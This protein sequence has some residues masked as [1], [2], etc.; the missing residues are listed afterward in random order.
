MKSFELTADSK[1]IL[2]LCGIFSENHT[3][4]E[5][6][7]LTLTEYNKVVSLLV[8]LKLSPRDILDQDILLDLKNELDAV[9][10]YRRIENLAK[11]GGALAL[12]I[13]SWFNKGLWVLTRNDKSYPPELKKR[14][15]NYAPPV[16]YGCGDRTLLKTD[17]LAVVG[18]RKVDSEGERFT[19]EIGMFCA[20]H[21]ISIISGGARGVDQV[22]MLTTLN[23]YGTAIGVLADSL[24]K[25]SVSSKYRNAIIDKRLLLLSPYSPE[26]RFNI[27]NA[28]G[29]NKYIYALSTFALV[30]SA[31]KGEGGTWAGAKEELKRGA[32]VPVFVRIEGNVP[33]G[34]LELIKMGARPFPRQPWKKS[35]FKDLAVSATT[36][37]GIAEQT[38]M[39]DI[40]DNNKEI[41]E[42]SHSRLLESN[43]E[44]KNSG[45]EIFAAVLP[46]LLSH[47]RDWVTVD[48]LVNTLDVRKIQI[49]DWINRGIEIGQ[50]E[51]KKR[52]LQYRQRIES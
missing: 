39:F 40:H 5:I 7:P 46:M 43:Q 22:A 45:N 34:N 38:S 13:E 10:G 51:K 28:M 17:S 21:N 30:I 18:S 35:L 37:K 19:E 27:G 29:R 42:N 15:G 47:M 16:L 8:S 9:V 32:G 12:T 2:L 33:P 26:A 11:R 3:H 31:E 52:P 49:Q 4:D 36:Q 20:N 25:S 48:S 14:L 41:K 1:A 24:L 50:I 23:N 6:K 44:A